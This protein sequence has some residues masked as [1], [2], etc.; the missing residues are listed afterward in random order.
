MSRSD[1]VKQTISDLS[2]FCND[3]DLQSLLLVGTCTRSLAMSTLEDIEKIEVT[4][5][6]PNQS[7]RLGTLFSSEVLKKSPEVN[8]NICTIKLDELNVQFQEDAVA[9]YMQNQEVVQWLKKYEL[10]SP[11][12]RNI[13]S[14]DF[15][16]NTLIYSLHDQRMI[17]VFGMA[18]KDLESETVRS[19]L[20][21]KMLMDFNPIAALRAIRFACK[22]SFH[23]DKE[24]RA[25]IR[26]CTEPIKK[27]Y[28]KERIFLE[29]NKILKVDIEK[30]VEMFR[31]YDLG[32]LLTKQQIKVIKEKIGHEDN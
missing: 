6:I 17:D 1:C 31:D 8:K 25:A 19:I 16:I 22:Y 13:F 3:Y 7:I 15:T 14:R 27:A 24:L 30:A 2:K 9:G 21:A 4:S 26:G 10:N 18:A 11:I 20:P 29:V 28:S 5:Y 32:G 23:I 12:Y